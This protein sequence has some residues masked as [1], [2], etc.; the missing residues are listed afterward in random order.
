MQAYCMPA[1]E[2]SPGFLLLLPFIHYPVQ[3]GNMS[4][5]HSSITLSFL[6]LLLIIAAPS[7]S[8]EF[9]IIDDS[10]VIGR[11]YGYPSGTPE[12]G[13]TETGNLDFV[14]ET[15]VYG[16]NLELIEVGVDGETFIGFFS[17]LRLRYRAHEQ[18][19]IEAGALIGYD[20]GDGENVD[21]IEPLLRLVYEHIEKTYIIGGTI[22]RTHAMHDALLDDTSAFNENAEQGLQFRADFDNFKQD[23]WI[24]WRVRETSD[25]SERFDTGTV[26]QF[27]TGNLWLDAQLLFR[28]TGGQQNIEDKVEH[29]IAW[30]AG[31]SYGFAHDV[32]IPFNTT[33]EEIRIGGYFI[34]DHEVPDDK[35]GLSSTD[36]AGFEG[37]IHF[38]IRPSRDIKVRIFGTYFKGD[39]LLARAG[40]PLYG[41]D[42][43]SQV[44]TNVLLNLPAGLRI[45]AGFAGQIIHGK[46]AHT[47]QFYLSWGKGFTLSRGL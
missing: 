46:F 16:K 14:A 17:P 18:L 23:L 29:N 19:T 22:I 4:R 20:F 7:F 28:H 5:R 25:I 38:D 32:A 41:R 21:E 12:T 37:R 10:T 39:E 45:E 27:R 26:S 2:N 6:L 1:S 44:G 43:Y 15:T 13:H 35:S 40:D 33:L 34:A 31:G 11:N 3:G 36:G 47:E 24:N 42:E 30:L 9:P 8:G